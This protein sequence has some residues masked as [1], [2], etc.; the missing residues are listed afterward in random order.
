M[1]AK[2]AHHFALLRQALENIASFLGVGRVGYVL[3]Q[4]GVDE[5]GKVASI[6]NTLSHKNVY[7]YSADLMVPDNLSTLTEIVEKLQSKYGFVLHAD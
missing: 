5:P 7:S 4:I 1:P 6:L 2:S 3:Q